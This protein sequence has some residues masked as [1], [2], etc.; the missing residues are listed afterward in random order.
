MKLYILNY[1]NYFN[2]KLL[3]LEEINDYSDYIVLTAD[4][5]SFNPNDGKQTTQILN[6]YQSGDYLICTET[7]DEVETIVSRWFILEANRTRQGQYNLSLKRDV[8]AD[9]LDAIEEAPMFVEKGILKDT[10]KMIINNEGMQFNQIKSN[11]IL[12]K[13]KSN[14]PWIVGYVAKNFGGDTVSTDVDINLSADAVN[15]Y[16]TIGNIAKETGISEELLINMITLPGATHQEQLFSE[17][18]QLIY[19][20]KVYG[21]IG[22]EYGFRSWYTGELDYDSYKQIDIGTSYLKGG[23]SLL[24]AD[25]GATKANIYATPSNIADSIKNYKSAI[26]EDLPN[27][28]N[29]KYYASSA[30]LSKLSNA[31]GSGVTVLYLG[32]YYKLT[33]KQLGYATDTNTG[34][35]KYQTYASIGTAIDNATYA[36]KI[37]VRSDGDLRIITHDIKAYLQLEEISEY[38]ISGKISSSRNVLSSEAF[39]M[40]AM[41]YSD[42]YFD[43]LGETFVASGELSTKVASNLV[44]RLDKQCYDVQLLPYCPV[45]NM[46]DSYGEINTDNLNVNQDYN[47]LFAEKKKLQ[48]SYTISGNMT[49]NETTN[50]YTRTIDFSTLTD[51]RLFNY[52][53]INP[54]VIPITD[55]GVVQVGS[56]VT[57]VFKA[58]T[59]ERANE[60][61]IELDYTHTIT[62]YPIGIILYPN[63]NRFTVK[64][65]QS[66]SLTHSMKVESQVDTYRL[67]SPNYQGSFD[68]NVAK[69]GGKVECFYA[70]C[71]YKP[72]NPYI[73]VYPKFDWLYGQDYSDCR[74]LICGG[75]FSLPRVSDA[76]ASYQLNNK[77]YQNTFNRDIQYLDSNNSISMRNQMVSS[78]IGVLQA[79]SESAV[80]GMK[81][82]GSPIGAAVGAVVG[83]AASTVG[84]VIDTDAL[85]K[86]QREQKQLSID[87][88]NYQLGNIQALPYTI[89]KV[90]SFDINSKLYPFIEYY[91]ASEEEV[92]TLEDKI[93]YESMTVMRIGTISEFKQ[94][95][96][97]YIKGQ[98]I[99]LD[100]L[101]TDTNL[102]NDIYTELYKG[103]Y[104]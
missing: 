3:R 23:S 59:L 58:D 95:E 84:A 20:V 47:L 52:K 31:I 73:R 60:V 71:T 26:K 17:N 80:R 11:E 41:P 24:Y 28:L 66:L 98:L 61:I 53:Q 62:D 69:N 4:N 13:D 64:I 57:I 12:L 101:H 33:L 34:L 89:S 68:F 32:V 97:T 22:M 100:D 90:G 81:M 30:D 6:K 18:I 42:I 79:G 93:T 102:I 8:L 96:P 2:R 55:L 83:T 86:Q 77:N 70:D 50:E 88:Y 91:T 67:C 49:Y 51:F 78:A 16:T 75:D 54:K 48:T 37:S 82:T 15:D 29:R 35:Q 25:N 1:N 45:P 36:K 99:R 21:G 38:K 76:W 40:F 14:C 72:Y 74:G 44:T 9:N 65:D 87:K 46:L 104:Y 103:V 19:G 7:K 27:I 5:I 10:D 56:K 63:D 43:Y 94:D 92:K 85:A 39:D